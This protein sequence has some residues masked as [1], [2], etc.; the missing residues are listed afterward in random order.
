MVSF[1][2]VV[3]QGLYLTWILHLIR[4]FVCQILRVSDSS[5]HA[6]TTARWKSVGCITSQEDLWGIEAVL[7]AVGDHALH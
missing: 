7:E 3:F 1:F 5:I 4:N 6:E 2:A